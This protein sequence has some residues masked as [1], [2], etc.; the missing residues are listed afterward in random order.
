MIISA[1]TWNGLRENIETIPTERGECGRVSTRVSGQDP[2]AGPKGLHEGRAQHDHD[3]VSI[4]TRVQ[5]PLGWYCIYQIFTSCN[6]FMREI[7]VCEELSVG[8]EV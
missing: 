6:S 5:S 1:H 2:S 4:L 8:G 3:R 7:F